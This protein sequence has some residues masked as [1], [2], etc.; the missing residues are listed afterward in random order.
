MHSFPYTIVSTAT[1]YKDTHW[2]MM[3][4]MS[5]VILA[6]INSVKYY[7]VEKCYL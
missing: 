6:N 2:L 3:P 4:Q 7:L 5:Q 1:T